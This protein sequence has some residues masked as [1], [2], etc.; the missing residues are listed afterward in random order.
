MAGEADAVTPTAVDQVA[1][2]QVAEVVEAPVEAVSAT[3]QAIA[4]DANS[5]GSSAAGA[6][7]KGTPEKKSLLDVVKCAAEPKT[8]ARAEVR[9]MASDA[10][11][12]NTAVE[13]GRDTEKEGN[14]RKAWGG[15]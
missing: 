7:A 9:S 6:H 12:V 11:P 10:L 8:D 14:R 5:A 4:T 15:D 1:A 13:A 2:D 3:D